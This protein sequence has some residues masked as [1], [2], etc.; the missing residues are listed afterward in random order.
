MRGRHERLGS[1]RGRA[2]LLRD[3]EGIDVDVGVREVSE[4]T[5]RALEIPTIL[6]YPPR[7]NLTII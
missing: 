6:S 4:F 7:L 2:A 3:L 1:W 5:F